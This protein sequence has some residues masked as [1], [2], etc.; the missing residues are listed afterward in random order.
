MITLRAI[1]I[2]FSLC[3]ISS[4]LVSANDKNKIELGILSYLYEAPTGK[5]V[6]IK[7]QIKNISS[8][9]LTFPR[10][11]YIKWFI[12]TISHASD[13]TELSVK[14]SPF[15]MNENGF[16][17][18]ILKP[19]DTVEVE[20]WHIFPKPGHYGFIVHFDGPKEGEPW[21]FQAGHIESKVISVEAHDE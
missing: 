4:V 12:T 7:V 2:T 10:E 13:N 8:D 21:P 19:N 14:H 15:V 1:F 9:D 6:T 5:P 20:V 11:E 3:M 17:G 16:K 18:G